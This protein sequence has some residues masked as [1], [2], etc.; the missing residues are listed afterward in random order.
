MTKLLK[1]AFT[2]VSKL[3]EKD[4][5]ELA[6]MILAELASESRWGQAFNNSKDE[7]SRLAD[8]AINEYRKGKTQSLDPETL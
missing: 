4:Q 5:D 2:E 6:S 8:E 7:L 3:S 1:K